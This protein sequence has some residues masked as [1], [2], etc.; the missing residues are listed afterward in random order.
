V[1]SYGPDHFSRPPLAM[2]DTAPQFEFVGPTADP[3]RS[4]ALLRQGPVIL[5]FYRGAW[6]AC[7]QTDLRDLTHT[8]PE[9]RKTHTTVLGVFHQLS[10]E[11]CTRISH[12]YGLNFPLVDDVDGRTAEA[13]GIRRSAT[14][15]AEFGPELLALKEGEPWILP[16][17]ARYVIGPDGV[18]ARSEVVFDYDKRSDA[19]GLIPILEHLGRKADDWTRLSDLR[20]DWQP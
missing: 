14:K 13:F 6:C 10:S 12:E 11:S 5:T 18:I 1:T 8:M 3:L 7:C 2:G 15:I 16:M 4:S 20:T 19:A 9:L 17:Q